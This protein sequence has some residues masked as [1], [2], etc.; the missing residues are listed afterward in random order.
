M[1]HTLSDT[2]PSRSQLLRVSLAV[3][4]PFSGR[5]R[6]DGAD[7]SGVGIPEGYKGA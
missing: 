7:G 3:H 2:A 6:L 1:P 5:G 4:G